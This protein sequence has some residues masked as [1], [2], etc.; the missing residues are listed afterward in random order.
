MNFASQITR[1]PI[2][3]N[4]ERG[5]EIAALFADATPKLHDLIQGTAGCSPYLSVI[6]KRQ[7]DWLHVAF[8]NP[9]TAVENLFCELR[10]AKLEQLKPLLRQ[11]KAKIAAITALADLGGIWPLEKVTGTLTDFADLAVDVALKALIAAEIK[12]KKLP[13]MSENDIA[14]AG[15][16]VVLAMGK[17]GAHELNYSSDIDLICLFDETRFSAD[18]YQD[19]RAAFIRVT[20]KMTALLSDITTDGYVFRTDLRLRPDP[21]TTPVCLSM[22]SAMRYYEGL[23]RTWERAAHIKARACAGDIAAGQAYLTNL[24]PF[25][26]RKHLDFAAIQDAHDMRLRIRQH[27]GLGGPIT[28]EGHNMKLGRGGIR[29][30]EFFTQTRQIIAGGRD[31]SL[32]SRETVPALLALVEKGWVPQDVA[33]LLIQRYRNHREV[34]HRLQMVND[35]QTHDL[36]KQPEEFD[37]LANFMGMNDTGKL[38]KKLM[39]ELSEVH[40]LTEG[41]FAPSDTAEPVTEALPQGSDDIIARW[42]NYP[43]MRSSRAVEIF[44]T[45]RPDIMAGLQKSAHPFEALVQFDGFLAGL[46]AG[47]QLFSLFQAN[48]QLIDLII[49]IC[50]TAP[51][52]ARHLSHNSQVLD[53]VLGGDFFLPWPGKQ[54]LQQQLSAH[55]NRIDDYERKLDAARRWKKEWHF[56]IGVH[57]L[58]GLLDAYEAGRQYADLAEASLAALWGPITQHFAQ[59]HGDAPGN[60]AVVLGMGSLG[61]GQLNAGSDLDLIVIYDADGCDESTGRRPLLTRPY[62][63]RLTQALVTALSAPMSEGRLYEVDMRLRPSGRQG[64]VATSLQSFVSY[65]Q[66]EAWTWEH[67]ALT[68]ARFVAGNASLG[69]QLETFRQSLLQDKSKGVD[70][71]KDVADMRARLAEAKPAR[72][73]WEAKLGP[74]RMQDIELVAET[75]ALLAADPAHDIMA[76]LAAGI[77]VGWL[78]N[79]QHD[80]LVKAYKMFWQLRE[81]SKLLTENALEMAEIGEGGRAFVLRELGYD[82]VETLKN[83]LD[84]V[85]DAANKVVD[86]VLEC[87][88][89]A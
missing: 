26:W 58:R 51:V 60:G 34:E 9:Q 12:R 25:I 27:K 18:D 32:R 31:P 22:D 55:L 5:A 48:P 50:A 7:S 57:H 86:Q 52:L 42:P 82:R 20:R 1:T 70:V 83:A 43:A 88:K 76:Q 47:V 65:Q 24:L 30:I 13:G 72:D 11:A 29:E 28:L 85:A 8:E 62:Y 45:L 68:R 89:V 41:F 79:D 71:L 35:A 64:P 4:L 15:G 59:K 36:P 77:R 38:R 53:A 44:E 37:L 19:A 2:P 21:S 63:S 66:D 16:M 39:Q 17:M 54:A 74:G 84:S 56:R 49:D 75:A 33:K 61:A 87:P 10:A 23:G 40:D 69:Q 46:P 81:T 14:T 67:L 80:T 6:I 78:T 3:H 73:E